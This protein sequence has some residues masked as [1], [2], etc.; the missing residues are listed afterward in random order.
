MFKIKHRIYNLT[1]EYTHNQKNVCLNQTTTFSLFRII[2]RNTFLL[3]LTKNLF[4][5]NIWKISTLW[6]E[7]I[8]FL[9]I[10]FFK[11]SIILDK[12]LCKLDTIDH[13]AEVSPALK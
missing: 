2:D 10:H 8:N 1:K 5:F 12:Q 13:T 4:N 9:P 7:K 3:Q 11:T 6:I